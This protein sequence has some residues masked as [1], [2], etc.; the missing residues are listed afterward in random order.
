MAETTYKRGTRKPK[1]DVAPAP[2]AETPDLYRFFG[3]GI[4]RFRIRNL[5]T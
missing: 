1:S 3:H 2:A 5:V 4:A